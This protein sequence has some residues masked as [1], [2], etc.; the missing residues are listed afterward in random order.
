MKNPTLGGCSGRCATAALL[1]W[2]EADP[3]PHLP[4]NRSGP[5]PATRVAGTGPAG[6]RLL[7]PGMVEPAA[8]LTA[9]DRH[10]DGLFAGEGGADGP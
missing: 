10:L 2:R 7:E 3:P 1:P 5:V 8:V 6:S 4:P 9:V